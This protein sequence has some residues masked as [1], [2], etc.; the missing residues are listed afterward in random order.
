MKLG[1]S[2]T[3]DHIPLHLIVVKI[4]VQRSVAVYLTA[5]L[6]SLH[7]SR[8]IIALVSLEERLGC[9]CHL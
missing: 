5:G 9:R 7:S 6:G 8:T 4:K 3:L 1:A 2:A